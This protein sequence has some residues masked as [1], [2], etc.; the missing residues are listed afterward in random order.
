MSTVK[1]GE[2]NQ[3]SQASSNFAEGKAL[4]R[5]PDI[6]HPTKWV[7]VVEEVDKERVSSLKTKIEEI[8]PYVGLTSEIA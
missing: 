4:Q 1:P 5:L 6:D 2:T 7:T 3:P 8:L